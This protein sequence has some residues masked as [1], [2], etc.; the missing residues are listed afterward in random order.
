MRGP[1]TAVRL[2]AARLAAAWVVGVPLAAL[3]GDRR[4]GGPRLAHHRPRSALASAFL[5]THGG[6]G[7]RGLGS[8]REKRRPLHT[9]PDAVVEVLYLG[10]IASVGGLPNLYLPPPPRPLSHVT[11]LSRCLSASRLPQRSSRQS[12]SAVRSRLPVKMAPS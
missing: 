9:N 12:S 1:A 10:L 11:H 7:P 8:Y 6:A 5:D 4:W 2:W 3:E